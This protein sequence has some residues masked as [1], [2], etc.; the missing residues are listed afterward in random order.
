MLK[1]YKLYVVDLFEEVVSGEYILE[2]F[3]MMRVLEL[4]KEGI[5]KWVGV[6]DEDCFGC[7]DKI[8]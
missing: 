2:C 7:G 5:I 3:K 1:K 6:M 8:D 4:F